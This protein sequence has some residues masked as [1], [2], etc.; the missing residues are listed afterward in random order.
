M[1]FPYNLNDIR[2]SEK[3]MFLGLVYKKGPFSISEE[4]NIKDAIEQYRVVSPLSASL[5]RTLLSH[6]TSPEARAYGR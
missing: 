2:I 6:R 1:L 5:T 3:Y 4:Q